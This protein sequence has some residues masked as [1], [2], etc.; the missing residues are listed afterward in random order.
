MNRQNPNRMMKKILTFSAFALLCVP[1]ASAQR[2]SFAKISSEL[3]QLFMENRV[4]QFAST[5][6]NAPE[7]PTICAFVRISGDADAV[8]KA[9]ACKPL[10]SFGNILIVNIPINELA[11][12]SQSRQ[13]CRIEAGQSCSILMDTTAN[14][15]NA[16]PVYSAQSLPQAYTGKGVVVGVQ[17]I[18]FDLTHPNFCD[19]TG[20]TLRI[21]ALWDQ[22]STDTIGSS[23]PVGRDYATP[24]ALLTLRHTRDGLQESHGT[25]TLG[26]AAGSGFKSPYR[27]MAWESDICLVANLTSENKNLVDEKYLLKFTTATDALGFKYIFDYAKRHNQPCVISFSEGSMSNFD[28][29]MQLY[30]SVLDSLQGPGR[31]I[32]AAAG[33]EGARPGYLRKALGTDSAGTFVAHNNG[34][35]RVST[36]SKDR[37]LLRLRFHRVGALTTYDIDTRTLLA[38]KDSQTVDTLTFGK[39]R[40]EI[41]A[42]AYPKDE[43]GALAYDMYLRSLDSRSYVPPLA[44]ILIGATADVEMYRGTG[45]WETNKSEPALLGGDNTHCILSPA[46]S[47]AVIAVG[48]TSYRTHVINYK[49]EKKRFER[50]TGGE[51]ATY[52]SVGPTTDGRIKP[53][54]MAPGTNIISSYNSFYIANN[55]NNSDV[56]WDVAHFEHNG[57]TYA[58]NANS[59]TSMATPAVAGAVALWLQ[60]KP[61]LTTDEVRRTMAQ[62]SI[63]HDASLPSPNNLYG[64][65]QIDVY[66][67]LLHILGIT[68][69]KGIYQHQPQGLSIVPCDNN[70]LQITFAD[71]QPHACTLR[72]YSLSGSLVLSRPRTLLPAQC[73]VPLDMPLTGVYVVQIQADNAKHSGSTLVRFASK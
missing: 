2:P 62:T 25:H 34:R 3:R 33:N 36:K 61:T 6:T 63:Q 44:L 55:P 4:T 70:K 54:V 16:L 40:Y 8:F 49:G 72:I 59:G 1:F 45:L 52:S 22:L 48:A 20:Q 46:L 30:H 32:V 60:A 47:S 64:Y 67:G 41:T 43:E 65:G 27:G 29:D 53:D 5:R 42:V 7:Q 18:G 19:S 23:Q 17:D 14:I 68:K 56:Q 26:I 13:V 57:H 51:R 71:A 39:L 50:G 66:R 73:V 12:L 9:R 58:W 38:A 31:I 10:A 24:D 21:K 28:N 37:F 69:V 15:I 35:I 11:K